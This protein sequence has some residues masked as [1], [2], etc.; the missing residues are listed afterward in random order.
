[1]IFLT[2]FDHLLIVND[3]RRT[4]VCD[5]LNNRISKPMGTRRT[6]EYIFMNTKINKD[7]VKLAVFHLTTFVSEVIYKTDSTLELPI[8]FEMIKHPT[9]LYVDKALL[10]TSKN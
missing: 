7:E 8:V 4:V 10:V 5:E 2:K 1:M 6:I 9:R 3:G